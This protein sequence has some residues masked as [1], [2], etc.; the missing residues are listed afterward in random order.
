MRR[1]NTRL[2]VAAGLVAALTGGVEAT[3][4]FMQI[5]QVIGGVNGDTTAQAV[6][7]RMR[8]LGQNLLGGAKLWVHDASGSNPVLLIDFLT[9]V[10]VG[11]G[12]ARV[13]I[14]SASF[15]L[16]T[17][18]TTINDFAM[19]N[20]IPASY[21]A[22]GSMTFENNLGSQIYWRLSWGGAGYTGSNAG[23]CLN[24]DSVCVHFAG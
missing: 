14:G 20:L 6:Q 22:A 13:L 1:R 7:L 9:S 18:P 10:P 19:T 11:V 12:G 21:L 17:T 5:E 4:H 15:K 8:S 2:I 3:F 23:S 16:E 24:D